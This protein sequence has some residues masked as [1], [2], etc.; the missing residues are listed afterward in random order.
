MTT[1]SLTV[2]GMSC[3]GC[4]QRVTTV[5]GRLDGVGGVEADHRSGTVRLDYD[6]SL[7]TPEVITS[8]LGDAGY[9]PSEGADR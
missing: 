8:R 1:L 4:E 6:P 7:L 3:A 2:H 9:E 5:L